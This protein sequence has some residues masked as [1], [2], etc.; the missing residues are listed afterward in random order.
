MVAGYSK[1]SLPDK[2]G[3]KDSFKIALVGAPERYDTQLGIPRG[4]VTRGE[5]PDGPLDFVQFFCKEK[6]ELE[7]RFPILKQALASNGMLWVSWP[8]RSSGVET[9]LN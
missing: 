7:K 4:K 3:I 1:R 9:D 8:K 2:L 5:S 6:Q